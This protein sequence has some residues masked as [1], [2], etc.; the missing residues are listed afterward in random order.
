MG[1]V[2]QLPAVIGYDI[3]GTVV[4]TGREVTSF[5]VGSHVFTQASIKYPACGGLQEYT[6]IDHQYSA[7]VPQNISDLDAAAFSTCTVTSALSLF[8]PMGFG[9]PFPGTPES[10][11]FDY[12]SLKLVIVGAGTNTGKFG[13][14]LARIAGIGTI[15]AVASLSGQVELKE[16]GATHIIS[17]QAP[18]I[19]SQVREIVGDKL[20]Y[21][22]DTYN[23]TEGLSQ[24]AKLLSRSEKGKLVRLVRGPPVTSVTT[25]EGVGFEEKQIIGL[26]SGIPEFGAMLWRQLPAW[27]EEGHLKCPKYNVIEGL[28][29]VKV[30]SALDDLKLKSGK[31]WHVRISKADL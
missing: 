31:R 12:Q 21:V 10:K 20:L 18:D 24:S 17:R 23:S 30:N 6:I 14:Q 29:A 1:F 27:V 11:D 28:D 13:I 26:S 19:E 2:K 8:S 22:Y 25:I 5:P 3:V 16:L 9:I 15:I 4:K 7:L